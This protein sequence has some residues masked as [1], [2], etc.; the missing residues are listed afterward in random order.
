MS[1]KQHEAGNP[2]KSA[3]PEGTTDSNRS[4]DTGAINLG[5]LG[6]AMV[7]WIPHLRVKGENAIYETTLRAALT[8]PFAN[9]PDACVVPY[10]CSPGRRLKGEHASEPSL[11]IAWALVDVDGPRKAFKGRAIPG[12]AQAA[13]DAWVVE[14]LNLASTFRTPPIAWVTPNGIRLLWA[15]LPG[16]VTPADYTP[17]YAALLDELETHGMSG[18]DRGC[19]DWTRLQRLPHGAELVLPAGGVPTIQLPV[20][21]G[22]SMLPAS[23]GAMIGPVT[24]C[25]LFRMVEA[26]DPDAIGEVSPDVAPIRCPWDD[27]HSTAGRAIDSSTA[28]LADRQG[29]RMGV[30]VCKHAHCADRS[31]GDLLDLLKLDA[32]AAAI[33]AEHDRA[34]SELANALLGAPA[35]DNAESRPPAV[36]EADASELDTQLA[37]WRFR[38]ILLPKGGVEC[39]SENLDV[40]FEHHP[41][42]KGVFG[43]DEL[44]NQVVVLRDGP[45]D[46]LQAGMRWTAD[47][48]HPVQRWFNRQLHIKP[49]VDI[50]AAAIKSVAQRC[51]PFHPV[52]DYLND[53]RA[54]WDGNQRSLVAYLGTESSPY[55][56]AACAAWL[57]SAVARVMRPGCKADCL[58]ILEGEQ[59]RFKSSAVR[60]LAGESFV[61]EVSSDD[62]RGKDFM[63]DMAGKWI[64][65]IPEIDRL[66][67]SRDESTLKAMLS[68][69]VDRYRP[70]FGRS[71]QDFP[72]QAVFAGTTNRQDYLRDATGNRRYWPLW[73]E[74]IDLEGLLRDRDALWG[75]AVAEFE[76]GDPWWLPETVEVAARVQQAARLEQDV[77]HDA[78]EA[79]VATQE[80]VFTSTEAI[81][82]V[83]GHKVGDVGARRVG[84]IGQSERN[85]IARVLRALAFKHVSTERGAVKGW[86][87]RRPTPHD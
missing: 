7:L 65:E 74:K 35:N 28:I 51:S 73:C 29:K 76:S 61:Y 19:V 54:R 69:Q 21:V 79:W 68:K 56:E 62:V 83:D 2:A 12:H 16:S 50:L 44:A 38:T 59:G 33:L 22:V 60:V 45:V 8:D 41:E 52:R 81:V 66:I 82:G 11:Q 71:S 30:F 70:S 25:T 6:D 40:A 46:G 26:A 36:R 87:W 85:R 1:A 39:C 20:T 58:L 5:P 13:H 32:A 84:D 37:T 10:T 27:E 49:G 34:N 72:R 14:T 55:S 4:T 63:Q 31:N 78:V 48:A 47:D 77:W 15:L 67:A 18:L 43:F 80:D 24:E 57:R 17:R 86:Y 23:L 9:Y 75:Q 42:W 53:C 3:G 64:G